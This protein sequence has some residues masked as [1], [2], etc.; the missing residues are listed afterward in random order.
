MKYDY[1]IKS[2]ERKGDAY[3]FLN[4]DMSKDRLSDFVLKSDGLRDYSWKQGKGEMMIEARLDISAFEKEKKA[5]VIVD[6]VN[7][8]YCNLDIYFDPSHFKVERRSNVD[9]LEEKIEVSPNPFIE[10]VYA[11]LSSSERGESEWTIYSIDG[12]LVYQSHKTIESDIEEFKFDLT[13]FESGVYYLKS[14]L[15]NGKILMKKI[16][17]MK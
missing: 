8:E 15:P 2:D 1:Y 17:K 12:R 14:K 13:N 10:A 5:Y 6:F 16:V 4:I 11:R 7:P 3:I 9:V